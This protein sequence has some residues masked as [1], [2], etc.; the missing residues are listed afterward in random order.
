MSDNYY[1]RSSSWVY[2]SDGNY[3]H[4]KRS[5]INP[6]T[7]REGYW[8]TNPKEWDK[9]YQEHLKEESDKELD[10][11]WKELEDEVEKQL[12]KIKSVK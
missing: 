8:Y 5:I 2:D 3:L 10:S 11:M 6:N 9:R 4:S 12:N 7:E 1:D